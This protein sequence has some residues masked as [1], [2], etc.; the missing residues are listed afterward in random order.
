M[1]DDAPN[2]FDSLGLASSPPDTSELPQTT[3]KKK[4]SGQLSQ[5]KLLRIL[6]VADRINSKTALEDDALA[7][8]ARALVQATL[9][10]SDPGD[11][12]A[13]GRDNGNYR[14]SIE[15]GY[16]IRDKHPVSIGLPYGVIPRLLMFWITTEAV[17]TKKR[18]LSLGSSLAAFMT[19]VGLNPSTGGGP[20]SDAARLKEQM[21]RLFSARV[22]F[23][24]DDHDSE[25][26]RKHYDI[27]NEVKLWWNPRNPDQDTLFHSSIEL[28]ESFFNEVTSRPV[29]VD[30]R[31]LSALKQSPLA[32]DLY[33]WLTYRVSYLKKPQLVTWKQIHDQFGADFSDI[34]AFRYKVRQY[35]ARIYAVY[36]AL[37]LEDTGSGLILQP[38]PSH[39]PGLIGN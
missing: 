7:F 28:G 17:R 30:V 22:A 1:I 13:W 32:L 23:T 18:E 37:S 9:P 39:V 24:Y 25:F 16:I 29:P 8:M 14:L 26:A 19:E 34:R 3:P 10:H 12:R 11:V 4:R 38:G 33:A 21:K 6:D 31:A 5:R 35:L 15:P 27:A 36:P 20:R 2:L